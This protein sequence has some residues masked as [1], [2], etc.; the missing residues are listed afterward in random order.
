LRIVTRWLT[1]VE[2]AAIPPVGK[3]F[4]MRFAQ[5]MGS[6]FSKRTT[7]AIFLLESCATFRHS[8]TQSR[9]SQI[10][11]RFPVEYGHSAMRGDSDRGTGPQQAPILRVTGAEP[12][13]GADPFP[14]QPVAPGNLPHAGPW[15]SLRQIGLRVTLY[16][17]HSGHKRVRGR[18]SESVLL[19][20][21]LRNTLAFVAIA[22]G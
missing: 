19:S 16:G 12:N 13:C 7:I 2:Y 21:Q 9:H 6:L 4:G 20:A 10:A 14:V 22:L 1:T 17:L 5:E 15:Q 11:C 8:F 18:S 3:R